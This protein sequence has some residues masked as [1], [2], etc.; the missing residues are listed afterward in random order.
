MS[1]LDW[2]DLDE[3]TRLQALQ[4]LEEQAAQQ[5]RFDATLDVTAQIEQHVGRELTGKELREVAQRI[6]TNPD[7]EFNADDYKI[8]PGDSERLHQYAVE[9]VQDVF[10]GTAPDTEEAE[11]A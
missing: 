7:F 11:A 8:D 4:A 5:E 10:D 3:N 6:D 1:D 2:D 9:A